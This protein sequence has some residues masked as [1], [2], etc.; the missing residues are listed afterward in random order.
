MIRGVLRL[1]NPMS[2]VVWLALF[3]PVPYVLPAAAL[4]LG[5]LILYSH[6]APWESRRPAR[7]A[8]AIFFLL[9]LLDVVS[10]AYS[11][12]FNGVR[13]GPLDL[14]ALARPLLAGVFSV[15]LIRHH[16]GTVRRTVESALLAAIYLTLFL[17]T[18]G[19]WSWSLFEPVESMG[20]LAALAA[21]HFAF[22]SRAPLR[23]AHAAASATVVLFCVPA[24]LPSSR[25][26]L[27][28]FWGSPVFGWG[29]ASYEPASSLG[30]QYLRWM[31]RNGILGAGLILTGLCFVGFRLLRDAW[32]DRGRLLGAA[33]FLGFTSGMLMTGA[34]LED[35]RL[36]ALTAFLIAGMH[37][38]SGS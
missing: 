18:T 35:F 20:Y 34:F 23:F 10:Y 8:A 13:T 11:M 38:G 25:E 19:L 5:G 9:A 36:F 1:H 17:R 15:Y 24:G 33:V 30:N 2:A 27:G 29:P 6:Q 22:I 12:A 32:N 14:W 16:D 21:I 7:E 37:E 26:A 4:I 3:A 28:L 31:L